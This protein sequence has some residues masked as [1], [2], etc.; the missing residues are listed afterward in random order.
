MKSISKFTGTTAFLFLLAVDIIVLL[1]ALVLLNHGHYGYAAEATTT[2]RSAT[3][4]RLRRRREH[5]RKL[6]A[7]HRKIG[8]HVRRDPPMTGGFFAV[9]NF[10]EDPVIV[11]A[12]TFVLQAVMQNNG[13]G[14]SSSSSSSPP[15]DFGTSSSSSSSSSAIITDFRIVEASQQVVAGLNIRLTMLFQDGKGNCV[16][17]CNVLVYNHFG[18]LSVTKWNE[19]LACQEVEAL[20]EEKSTTGNDN[21]NNDNDVVVLE[22]FSNPM[23]VWK[24]MNDPVMGGEL[25]TRL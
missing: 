21:D 11:E 20:L 9:A 13:D 19:E 1:P 4:G 12:A 15:Y 3:R 22:D 23:H 10:E 2:T 16:G 18:E 8:V 25:E 5:R 14:Y 6:S 7:S 24:E 17:A